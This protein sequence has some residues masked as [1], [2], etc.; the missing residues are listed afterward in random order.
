M[1]YLQFKSP[2]FWVA[3]MATTLALLGL[4]KVTAQTVTPAAIDFD[5]GPLIAKNNAANVVLA[6]SV[7]LPTSGGAYKDATYVDSK[8]Y[9]GY[10]NSK[11]CYTYPGLGA[12]PRTSVVFNASADYFSPTG[13]TDASYYCN[14]AGT[15]AGFSG[16]YLNYATMTDRKT[17]V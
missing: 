10:F 9:I 6:L 7:E 14:Q 8:E 16:N 13:D 3:V 15:G 11:R 17:H 12:V 4:Y 5:N 1:K 2:K